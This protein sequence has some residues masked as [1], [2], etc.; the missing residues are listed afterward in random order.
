MFDVRP[1]STD[2]A[3]PF[4]LNDH[5]KHQMVGACHR[6]G[7]FEDGQLVGVVLYGTPAGANVTASVCGPDHA[8]KVLVLSRLVVKTETPNGSSLLI[9][10]SLQLLPRP[11]IVLSYADQNVG[12]VGY[13]YQAANAIYTGLSAAVPTYELDDG[14]TVNHRHAERERVVR[15]TPQ[16]PKHRYVFFVGSRAEK[17][18]LRKALLLPVLS[19]PKGT[20]SA[21]HGQR[22]RRVRRVEYM[23]CPQCGGHFPPRRSDAKYCSPACRSLAY[24]HRQN[25]TDKR[26]V[27]PPTDRQELA[28]YPSSWSPERMPQNEADRLRAEAASFNPPGWTPW[29]RAVRLGLNGAGPAGG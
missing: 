29:R 5:Y 11:S 21:T 3:R 20:P 18:R 4:I 19:F 23:A 9:G 17:R 2:E 25:L 8:D 14:S 28:V 1:I 6:Y 13:C 22:S 26:Q 24:Y 10:R 12:H 15:T 27:G 16:L 7:L